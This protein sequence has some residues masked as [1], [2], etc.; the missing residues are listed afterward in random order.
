MN[1]KFDAGV[2]TVK[3]FDGNGRKLEEFLQPNFLAAQEVGELAIETDLLVESYV[4]NL[5]VYN[6]AEPP[7]KRWLP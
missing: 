2:Y 3:L 4:I 5:C 7:K 6:S 1:H